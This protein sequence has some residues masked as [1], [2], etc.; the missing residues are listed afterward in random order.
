MN[1]MGIENIV[2][3]Q[4]KQCSSICRQ[5]VFA[6]GALSWGLIK[7]DNEKADTLCLVVILLLIVL[8]M[9]IDIVQY[10]YYCLKFKSLI[11]MKNMIDH[12]PDY[13]K[14]DKV[15]MKKCYEIKRIRMEKKAF[16][17]FIAKIV[18]LPFI[19]VLTGIAL[20]G[21]L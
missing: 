3:E 8:Y 17:I 1:T 2:Y 18:I 5:V 4:S 6:L 7:T 10:L 9:T 13:T 21:F 15:K 19:I 14:T 12:Y 20:V 11:E 16:Y